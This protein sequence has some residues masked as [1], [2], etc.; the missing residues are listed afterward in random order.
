M[1][2][3]SSL[4]AHAPPPPAPP[5]PAVPQPAAESSLD[6]LRRNLLDESRVKGIWTAGEQVA[7]DPL[8]KLALRHIDVLNEGGIKSL[9]WPAELFGRAYITQEPSTAIIGDYRRT[10]SE[11][12]CAP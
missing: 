6:I 7:F 12:A 9:P 4:P 3:F 8:V 10:H 11:P 5:A 1:Q 2:T